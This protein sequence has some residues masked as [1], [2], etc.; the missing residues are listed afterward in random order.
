[1]NISSITPVYESDGT[2]MYFSATIN[3]DNG[4]GT[5]F[6]GSLKL[7]ADAF[8]ISGATRAAT[9]ALAT[10]LHQQEGE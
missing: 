1:M 9:E 4:S 5:S 7:P 8:D 10:M 2:L 6:V 3:G